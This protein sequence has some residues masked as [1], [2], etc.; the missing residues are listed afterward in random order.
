M[1]IIITKEDLD[2]SIKK[3]STTGDLCESCLITTSLRRQLNNPAICTNYSEIHTHFGDY[4]DR[5]IMLSKELWNL[6][7][8]FDNERYSEIILPLEVEVDLPKNWILV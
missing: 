1:K 3:Y 5:D 2:N 4:R 8:L 7:S 6:M